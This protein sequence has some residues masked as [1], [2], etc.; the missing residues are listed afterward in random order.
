MGGTRLPPSFTAF[1]IP[2]EVTLCGPQG[3]PRSRP[4]ALGA[5]S[6]RSQHLSAAVVSLGVSGSGKFPSLQS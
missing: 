1:W 3:C 5:A 6:E 2:A 4:A